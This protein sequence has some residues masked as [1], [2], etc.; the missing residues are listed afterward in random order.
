MSIDAAASPANAGA[1]NDVRPLW[2]VM[3]PTYNPTPH[4]REAILSVQAALDRCHASAHVE[5]VDDGSSVDVES[6]VRGW[7]L[8]DVQVHRRPANGGLGPCWNT[9]IDRAAGTLIHILHQ[10]DLVKPAFYARMTEL[11]RDVPT[12]GMYFCRPEF[13]DDQGPHIG[14]LEQ[15]DAG[16]IEHWL[17]KICSAQRVQC[18]AVVV[19]RDT[20]ARVGR[21]EPSLRYVI[22]WEMWIRIAAATPVAY[23]PEALA[24]Y[25]MHASAETR[26]VKTA[27]IA[28]RDFAV[29]LGFIGKTLDKASRRDCLASAEKFAVDVSNWTAQEAEAGRNRRAAA[30]EVRASLRY[31]WRSMGWR[32]RLRQARWYVRLLLGIPPLRRG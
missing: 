20:Y 12:A 10:D 3:I 22:D 19:R 16:L 8:T 23:L 18:S 6:M 5:L 31:L 26:R 7:G 9:C 17:E 1:A 28:T 21:F 30:R 25:R 4:L 27:G 14:E 2:S 29:A 32:Y 24:V 13:L 11:A 15:A